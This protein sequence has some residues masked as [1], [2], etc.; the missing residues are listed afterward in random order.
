MGLMYAMCQQWPSPA[1][2]CLPQQMQLQAG[3]YCRHCLW[4]SKWLLVF[5]HGVTLANYGFSFG[6]TQYWH[7]IHGWNSLD[8]PCFYNWWFSKLGLL[9]AEIPHQAVWRNCTCILALLC[10][11][12]HVMWHVAWRNQN[13]CCISLILSVNRVFELIQSENSWRPSPCTSVHN[14]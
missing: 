3:M 11:Q 2:L 7:Q 12:P 10:L 13:F 6:N 8:A 4:P 5:C 14:Q 9:L 1:S